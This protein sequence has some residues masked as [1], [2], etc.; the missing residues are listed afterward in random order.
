MKKK[1]IYRFCGL[2]KE[3]VKSSY[4]IPEFMYEPL[5]DSNRQMN[6]RS[7]TQPGVKEN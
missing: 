6:L 3:L 5:F 2:E 4:I 7:L 1:G